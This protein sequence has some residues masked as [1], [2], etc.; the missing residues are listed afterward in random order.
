MDEVLR[1]SENAARWRFAGQTSKILK[2][3]H[4]TDPA[5]M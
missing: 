1:P 4:P 3:K 5:A 2:F